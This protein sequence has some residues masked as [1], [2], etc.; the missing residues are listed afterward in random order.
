MEKNDASKTG[1]A[2][3]AG[4]GE[5][6]TRK[7]KKSGM[8]KA[9]RIVSYFTLVVFILLAG[10]GCGFVTATLNTKDDITDINP[11]AS[12]HIYDVKGREI[13]S[14]HAE[15]NRVPVK[16][17]NIP[18]ELQDAF[19]CIEDRRFDDHFGVDPWGILR[20][21]VANVLGGSV[22][23]GGSTITQQ[24]AKNAYLT[25]ERTLQR[26]VQEVFLAIKLE[27]KYTK[28]EIL[29]MYLNQIYFGQGAY[30]VEAA[31]LTYFGKHA[32]ELSLNE[33]AMLA[34]V[35]KSPNYYSPFHREGDSWPAQERM[36]VV[37]DSMQKFGRPAKK[38]S[39]GSALINEA[40]NTPIKLRDIKKGEQEEASYFIDYVLQELIA[41]P[42]FGADAVYMNGLK[43][44]TTIDLDLQRYAE[45]AVKNN[46]PLYSKYNG[47]QQPQAALV[48]INPH[49]GYIQAMVGGRGT[50]QF[51][52]AVLATRQ[53]GSAMK[54][55][56]FAAALTE[57]FTPDTIIE[58][59]PIKIGDW[60]PMNY[61]R[62]FNGKV[63]LRTVATFSLN[64]PTVRI[65][66]A[67]GMGKVIDLAEKM[68][69]TTLVREGSMNDM[70]LASSLGGLTRGV[71][72][73]EITSAYGTFANYGVHVP[74][75]GIIKV[76]DRYDNVLYQAEAAPTTVFSE[77]IA[78]EMND[79]LQSVVLAGTGTGANIGRP[80]AGKTGTTS[81][82]LD[83]WFV[84]YTPD[85]VTGVWIGCDDNEDLDGMTGGTLPASIW[86]VF[87]SAAT[88]GM[89]VKYFDGSRRSVAKP[90]KEILDPNSK[91]KNDPKKKT[92][93]DGKTSVKGKTEAPAGKETP[94][95]NE[96]PESAPEKNTAPAAQQAPA[97]SAPPP[98]GPS[99]GAGGKGKN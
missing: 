39:Y 11:V 57:N 50:D 24:L 45:Q 48:A 42:R 47:I 34:G 20:A 18:K 59:S 5:N 26:K 67:V 76:C 92:G 88:K 14:I 73:L 71:T 58:D 68:G 77:E 33:C 83:A 74:A 30:G 53:P 15:E 41:D 46:L 90:V 86:Q 10:I 84:G 6:R 66:Q 8:G 93:K 43:I 23:E 36:M 3:K 38:R 7:K 27:R 19:V 22:R 69:I 87:M 65:A 62:N 85:L 75:T 12:S 40:K 32:S 78:T 2:T 29:E 72:P 63:P 82:Y 16:L 35:P 80:A 54:P 64:V 31:A 28:D 61:N 94:K 70:N 44:Y 79:M 13:T 52:R 95:K 17:A 97:P 1:R 49:N 89:P 25:Q 21:A 9:V 4:T 51:N 60:E 96:A 99:I 98:A 55:F 37:L 81:D 91:G 56:V